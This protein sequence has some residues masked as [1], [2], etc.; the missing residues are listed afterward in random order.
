MRAKE[1]AKFNNQKSKTYLPNFLHELISYK[2][3]VSHVPTDFL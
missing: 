2:E 3:A 1:E